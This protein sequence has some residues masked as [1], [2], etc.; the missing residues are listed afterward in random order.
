MKTEEQI[1]RQY[2]LEI[3]QK[4]AYESILSESK[5]PRFVHDR[6]ELQQSRMEL[7]DWVLDQGD[8]QITSEIKSEQK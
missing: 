1:K 8:F 2:K 7:L 5:N 3:E 6:I 4:E